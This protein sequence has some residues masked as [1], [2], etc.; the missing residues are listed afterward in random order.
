[1]GQKRTRHASLNYL[2]G[3]SDKCVGDVDAESLE[4]ALLINPI[5]GSAVCCACAAS[6]HAAAEP[7]TALM[8][9]RRRIA[10]ILREA[11]DD[12]SFQSLSD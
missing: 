7:K 4:D 5:T 1:M 2:V 11:N 6:G 8:K 10:T 3:T 12:A 9:S